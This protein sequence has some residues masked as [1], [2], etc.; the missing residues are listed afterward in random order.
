MINHILCIIMSVNKILELLKEI[1]N[2]DIVILY[3][4]QL[5]IIMD[6]CDYQNHI[7]IYLKNRVLSEIQM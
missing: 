7:F 4:K 5:V 1:I 2:V 3:T 6:E